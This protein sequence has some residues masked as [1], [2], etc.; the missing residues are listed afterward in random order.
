ME[1]INFINNSQPAINDTNLNKLQDNV[2]DAIQEAQDTQNAKV[3]TT[4]ST[5]D[6]DT[7]SCNYINGI[8][9]SGSNTN[10]EYIKYADGTMICTS[11][12]RFENVAVTTAWG[13]LYDS[14]S[15]ELGN[16]PEVFVSIPKVFITS[17]N[18]TGQTSRACFIEWITGT[19]TSSWGST[20]VA[21]PTSGNS[22]LAFSL[23]AIG[24]WK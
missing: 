10:G 6:T 19:T 11:A 17:H 16:M 22:D 18:I 4:Y 15:L 21:R 3:K 2:E 23:L 14:P 7:Y 1:K 9:E 13:S 5:S 12:R 24:K 8:I 20:A